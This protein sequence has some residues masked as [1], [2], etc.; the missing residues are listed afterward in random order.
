MA[1]KILTVFEHRYHLLKRRSLVSVCYPQLLQEVGN[2]TEIG[3][4]RAAV[5]CR[6]RSSRMEALERR[7]IGPQVYLLDTACQFGPEPNNRI[8]WGNESN[9]GGFCSRPNAVV[10][11]VEDLLVTA[12]T[13]VVRGGLPYCSSTVPAAVATVVDTNPLLTDD[14][15]CSCYHRG[16]AWVNVQRKRHSFCP[17]EK[18]RHG[19]PA[20]TNQAIPSHEITT[21]PPMTD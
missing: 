17:D 5:G 18:H 8:V 1:H 2:S 21:A 9:N 4:G 13:T 7:Q 20:R 6:C 10:V 3:T 16:V 11:V 15:A 19:K 12:F 14:A